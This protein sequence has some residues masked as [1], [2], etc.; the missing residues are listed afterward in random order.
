MN[1]GIQAIKERL[2]TDSIL[3]AFN[4]YGIFLLIGIKNCF[5]IS[6]GVFFIIF[7]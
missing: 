4:F 6:K 3:P 5:S 1:A 2:I 7:R